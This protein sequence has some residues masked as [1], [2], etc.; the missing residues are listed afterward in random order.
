MV[1]PL[2]GPEVNTTDP[3]YYHW[4]QWIFLQLYKHGL[5]YKKEM[6]VN[7][8]PACKIVLAN[9]E[10]IDGARER[11]GAVTTHIVK[12]QWML[13]ITEYADKLW[14][15]LDQLDFIER[16]AAA[17]QLDRSARTVLI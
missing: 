13:R 17:A 16:Q 15:D 9:E 12:S 4:T 5:A 3:A 7:W 11:C 6:N 1:I 2:I 10:V 8:C 14:T